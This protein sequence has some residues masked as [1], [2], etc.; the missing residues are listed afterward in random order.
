MLRSL[1]FLAGVGLCAAGIY[2]DDHW[3]YATKLSSDDELNAMVAEAVE[4][5]K[6]LF[7]RWIASEG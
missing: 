6:T 4:G 1:A 3:Q 7:I 2:P 5:D